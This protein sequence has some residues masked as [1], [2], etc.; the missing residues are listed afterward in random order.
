MI[1]EK[2]PG[3]SR[4]QGH[5]PTRPRRRGGPTNGGTNLWTETQQEASQARL[6]PG[7]SWSE[8]HHGMPQGCTRP[9]QIHTSP[10]QQGCHLVLADGGFCIATLPG[11]PVPH[12]GGAW[13][14]AVNPSRGWGFFLPRRQNLR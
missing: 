1:N 11:K 3:I 14:G 2:R 7:P 8:L 13:R 10:P 6:R 12:I 9:S 5:Q 4:A